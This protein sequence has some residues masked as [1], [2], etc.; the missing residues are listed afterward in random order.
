MAGDSIPADQEKVW[1]AIAEKT[2]DNINVMLDITYIPWADYQAQVQTMI[3][4]GDKIDIFLSFG[5]GNALGANTSVA[6][7]IAIPL[8]DLLEQYGSSIL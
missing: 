7:G 2:R 4:A 3:A 6:N 8:N 5:E 1:Q